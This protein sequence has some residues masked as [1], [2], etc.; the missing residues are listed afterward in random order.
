MYLTCDKVPREVRVSYILTGYR[1]TDTTFKYCCKSTLGLHNE[2]FNIWSHLLPLLYFIWIAVDIHHDLSGQT[3]ITCSFL[4]LYCN[5]AGV[6]VLMLLSSLAHIFH[7]VSHKWR[8]LCFMCDYAAIGFYGVSAAI[9]GYYYSRYSKYW[10]T[11]P[12]IFI[13]LSIMSAVIATIGCC[14]TR[15]D[16]HNKYIYYIR[17]GTYVFPYVVSSTP[18]F[19]RI[20]L[21][22]ESM[23]STSQFI[24]FKH[25][26]FMVLAAIFNVTRIPERWSPGTFDI[27]GQSHQIFHILIFLGVKECL[28]VMVHD[29]KTRNFDAIYETNTEPTLFSTF[30][31]MLIL[32]LLSIG[33]VLRFWQEIQKQKVKRHKNPKA[34]H[35]D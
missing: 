24:Y 18:M 5:M 7:A 29:I 20:F 2:T 16:M 8:H 25:V 14:Y 31:N 4:P 33:V 22:P 23:D 15:I 13:A 28:Y 9:P 1:P 11:D 26:L 3:N 35:Q 30:G 6:C 12:N 10:I 27:I 34:V 17:T 19:C 21:E 32:T